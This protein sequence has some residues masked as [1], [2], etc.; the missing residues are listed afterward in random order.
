MHAF[1]LL[2]TAALL[3]QNSATPAS[4]R[5]HRA[6]SPPAIDGRLNDAVWLSSESAQTFRQIEPN[7]GEAATERTEVRVLY[8]D[9]SLYV[10]MRLYDREPNKIVTRLSRRDD[11]PDADR[12]TFYIDPL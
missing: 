6:E 10:G 2:L 9:S 3:L 4:L 11:D 7:E 12:I 8:D 1:G 5:A